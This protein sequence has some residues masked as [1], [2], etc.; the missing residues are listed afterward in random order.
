MQSHTL[1]HP[2]DMR[3]L[4]DA[5]LSKELVMSRASIVKHIGRPVF[6][7]AYPDGKH[8]P[9]VARAVAAAGYQVGITEDWGS[10]ETSRNM[11]ELHR[12]SIHKRFAQSLRDV[13]AAGCTG[14]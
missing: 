7:F 5:Q 13:R 12:Y 9:R 6:A 14:G 8:D 2:E 10:A 4:G 11:M 1:S 3:P